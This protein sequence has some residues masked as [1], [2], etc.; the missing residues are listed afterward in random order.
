MCPY[1]RTTCFLDRN[2]GPLPSRPSPGE[3][4]VCVTRGG[5]SKPRHETLGDRW[6]SGTAGTR[7]LSGG[8]PRGPARSNPGVCCSVQTLLEFR[9]A[10]RRTQ[11]QDTRSRAAPTPGAVTCAWGSTLLPF[12]SAPARP[13]R[14]FVGP[15]C[16]PAGRGETAPDGYPGDQWG[17]DLER[18]TASHV[19]P[20]PRKD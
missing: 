6:P 10:L 5:D 3:P 12:P 13:E 2:W 19:L 16:N 7:A 9:K 1:M 4:L 15:Q 20:S 8:Q 18:V 11:P 17:Q 14:A